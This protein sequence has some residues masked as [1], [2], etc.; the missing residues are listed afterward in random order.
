MDPISFAIGV[1]SLASI[2]S[3]CIE[4][5]HIFQSIRGYN[6]DTDTVMLKLEIERALFIEWAQSVGLLKKHYVKVYLFNPETDKLVYDVVFKIKQLLDEAE[7]LARKYGLIKDD[8]WKSCYDSSK[9]TTGGCRQ[10]GA[11]SAA[12]KTP[13]SRKFMWTIYTRDEFESL[14]EQLHYFIERLG[15]M[16]KSVNQR[17]M[18]LKDLRGLGADF[19]KL[20]LIEANGD[21]DK[22]S[23][24]S[25]DGL[26][27]AYQHDGN[28][29]GGYDNWS[30]VMTVISSGRTGRH[31]YA[32][33]LALIQDLYSLR[34]PPPPPQ[35]QQWQPPPTEFLVVREF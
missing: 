27:M 8:S 16:V 23:V 15:Q 20:G 18:L 22:W 25:S 4:G 24:Q 1:V 17:Q 11:S 9:K 19:S 21:D 10:T 26:N 30:D 12:T 7:T 35:R 5:F 31:Y 34:P 2:V 14:I 32:A 13:L 3:T 29:V 6:H 33:P 28:D